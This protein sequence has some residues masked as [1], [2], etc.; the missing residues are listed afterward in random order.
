MQQSSKHQ[1]PDSFESLSSSSSA[2]HIEHESVDMD[3]HDRAVQR[4]AGRHAAK[5]SSAPFWLLFC[6]LLF[7]A[8]VVFFIRFIPT[9]FPK[10]DQGIV[11]V[12]DTEAVGTE[13]GT[14]P[15]PADETEK[16]ETG[17]GFRAW[18]KRIFVKE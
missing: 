4:S 7:I 17:T 6:L 12:T 2:G 14:V 9:R 13:A 18:F 3:T 1:Y 8:L 15:A 11:P 10:V 5:R 16:T